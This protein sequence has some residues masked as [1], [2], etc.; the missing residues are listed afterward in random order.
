M[1]E[2]QT[3]DQSLDVVEKIQRVL[4]V[5]GAKMMFLMF[6]LLCGIIGITFIYWMM[7]SQ[8]GLPIQINC[9]TALEMCK[10]LP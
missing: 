6:G 10:G 7:V 9:T 8:G 1:E 4:K 5:P 2:S 3:E